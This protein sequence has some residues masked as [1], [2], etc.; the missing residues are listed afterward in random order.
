MPSLCN[1]QGKV[2]GPEALLSLS[3][4]GRAL[5][6][7]DEKDPKVQVQDDIRRYDDSFALQLIFCYRLTNVFVA[8]STASPS[9]DSAVGQRADMTPAPY[10]MPFEMMPRS[11][12]EPPGG[13]DPTTMF[14]GLHDPMP[15]G[16]IHLGI[17]DDLVFNPVQNLFQD[18]DFGSW[19]FSF[20]D[21]AV[22]HFDPHGPSPATTA[23][24]GTANRGTRD[25][26][27]RYA[28]F[29]RSPWL[30]EPEDPT[31]YVQRDTEGL[32]LNE[33]E[34]LARSSSAFDRPP[35]D[36][37]G[38][39]TMTPATRD[40]LFAIVLAE[41]KNP[42]RVPSF[43]SL[44]LLEYLLQTHFVHDGHNPCESWIHAPT[45]NPQDTLP[46]LVATVIANGA[47]FIAVPAVWQFGLA[48]QEI[49]RQ[50]LY[51]I[52]RFSPPL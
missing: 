52:V 15:P 29:K 2:R 30:W 8:D 10:G 24:S 51:A 41:S 45:F 22:P 37:I 17:A 6:S 36:L 27:K 3:R 12:V 18:V 32:H 4:Q 5:R 20:G 44:E 39:L 47:S 9:E 50:R 19:D 42:A 14:A 16:P 46:E 23:T 43:P 25:T 13:V 28:A 49:I 7:S 33:T 26:A 31:D 48:L 34:A 21:L 35:G 11:V 38:K 1:G 40:R